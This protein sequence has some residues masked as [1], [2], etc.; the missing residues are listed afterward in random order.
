MKA[1]PWLG[2]IIVCSTV[3]VKGQ[4]PL[5]STLL[6]RAAAYVASY[7]ET[8]AGVV[9]EESYVQVVRSA[10]RRTLNSDVLLVRPISGSPWVQFRDIF[11]VDGRPVR[12]RTDRLARLFLHPSADSMAMAKNLTAESARYNIGDVERDIN[13]PFVALLVLQAQNQPRFRFTAERMSTRADANEDVVPKG[14]PSSRTFAAPGDAVVIR[15]QEIRPKTIIRRA[16][17]GDLPM[18]GRIWLRPD[19]GE[20]ALTE[21]EVESELIAAKVHVSYRRTPTLDVAVPIEMREVYRRLQWIS[22]EG[23]AV[24]SNVRRFQVGVEEKITPRR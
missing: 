18:R 1:S 20:I 17:G 21:L 19:T 16:N 22:L 15:F 23:T 4:T 24:Y 10:Q 6:T 3:M 14:V 7:S 2:I 8:M 13:V 9:L 11:A 12:D 5:P